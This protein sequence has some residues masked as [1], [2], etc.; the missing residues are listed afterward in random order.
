MKIVLYFLLDPN[1]FAPVQKNLTRIARFCSVLF[2]VIHSMY[3]FER[4]VDSCGSGN[5]LM[6]QIVAGA[7]SIGMLVFV[8]PMIA[9]RLV[10]EFET[11][12]G[13]CAKQFVD[14][15][16]FATIGTSKLATIHSAYRAILTG[17]TVIF[18]STLPLIISV[19]GI[20]LI[21]ITKQSPFLIK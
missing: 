1:R 11:I 19:G 4:V 16:H 3:P 9:N 6:M 20:A 14:T 8:F 7:A 21:F 2:V 5:F 12:A 17:F 18:V 10:V 13:S 15:G